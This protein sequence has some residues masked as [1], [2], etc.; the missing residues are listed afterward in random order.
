[1]THSI[2]QFLIQ[3][4]SNVTQPVDRV[5]LRLSAASGQIP[6]EA[7]GLEPSS[8]GMS[9]LL[10]LGDLVHFPTFLE[11][12]LTQIPQAFL[13]CLGKN[14]EL[15]RLNDTDRFHVASRRFTGRALRWYSQ[16]KSQIHTYG[17]FV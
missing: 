10:R 7:R 2:F 15:M 3:T 5:P 1:M 6:T 14:F 13:K 12:I 17:D 4:C 8:V 16:L 9:K 11:Q